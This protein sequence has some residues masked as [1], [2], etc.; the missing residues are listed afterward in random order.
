[1]LNADMTRVVDSSTNIQNGD[2]DPFEFVAEVFAGERIV[3]VQKSGA[4]RMLSVNAYR[5]QLERATAGQLRGHPAAVGALAIA[6]VD[7][8][9]ALPGAFTGGSANPVELFSAD[10]PRRIFFDV[11]GDL[12]PGAPAGNFTAT[13][14]IVRQKPDIAAADGVLVAAPGFAPFFG[15]SAAAPHAAAIAALLA[16][17]LPGV[18]NAQIVAAM[19]AGTLD[20]EAPGVDRDSGSGIV[21]PGLALAQIGAAPAAVVTGG[22]PVLAPLSGDGDRVIDPGE[23]WSVTLPL[24]NT[25]GRTAAA[26]QF[27][28]SSTSPQVSVGSAAVIGDLAAGA[29]NAGATVNFTLTA[30]FPCGAPL[31]LSA[32]ISYQGGRRASTTQP[33]VAVCGS[34]G[35][36]AT[37]AYSGA[38]AVIADGSD[39]AE[40]RIARCLFT[41]P[42][43]GVVRHADAGYGEARDAGARAGIVSPMGG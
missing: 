26:L 19:R 23:R 28:L 43:I 36:P 29:T 7:V 38:P 24:T 41:D 3:I 4:A 1:V 22:A 10:G 27:A 25:G 31:G 30:A 20:I 32:Q 16:E 42:A 34:A 9:T 11:N 40:E 2:D 6:A 8:A 17:E 21:M 37:R 14:G 5:G 12:L 13:G 18:T 35:V 39:S 33:I 15:T